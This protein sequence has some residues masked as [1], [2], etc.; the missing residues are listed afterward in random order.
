MKNKQKDKYQE[1]NDNFSEKFYVVE[2]HQFLSKEEAIKYA[3]YLME[4]EFKER[5]S[6]KCPK[7]NT[8]Y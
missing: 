4:K 3:K 2:G 6:P 5:E 1:E 8:T 7:K